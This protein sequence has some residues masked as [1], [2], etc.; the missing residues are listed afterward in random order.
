LQNLGNEEFQ[1]GNYQEAIE[2]YSKAIEINGNNA[3]Y[4]SNSK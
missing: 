4:F 3:I 1:R 2:L